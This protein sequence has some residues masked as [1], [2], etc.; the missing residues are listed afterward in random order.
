MENINF[1]KGLV[2]KLILK[3]IGPYKILK[4]YGNHS[5]KLELPS[6]L[7]Q[8]GIHDVF[9]ASLLRIHH[10]NDDRLFPGRTDS[11]IENDPQPEK[12][13]AVDKILSHSGVQE[14]AIFEIL[15]KAGDITWLP[16]YQITHLEALNHYMEALGVNDISR[17][18]RGQ[19]RLPTTDLQISIG[20]IE[21]SS[22]EYQLKENYILS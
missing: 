14:D 5:F 13:W 8:R 4:D 20:M 15:W 9:H 1:P 18:P 7:R 3:F 22:A 17:L 19:G 2:Q 21:V 12:E 6:R 10:P 11:Q 16:Y